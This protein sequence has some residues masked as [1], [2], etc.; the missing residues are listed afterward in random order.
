MNISEIFIILVVIIALFQNYNTYYK[1]RKYDL[2]DSDTYSHLRIAQE[3]RENGWIMKYHT[4]YF[5]GE[6]LL[7][8]YP[9]ML[10]IVLALLQN[11]FSLIFTKC[12][13]ILLNLATGMVVGI[14]MYYILNIPLDKSILSA[15][16]FIITHGILEATRVITPRSFGIL[17]LFLSVVG[18]SEYSTGEIQYCLLVII[19][20][21]CLYLSH[22]MGSQILIIFHVAL[23]IISPLIGYSLMFQFVLFQIISIMI[24]LILTNGQIRLVMTDHWSRVLLHFKY[25]NQWDGNKRLG[26]IKRIIT[27]NS[28]L[29]LLPWPIA[30]SMINMQNIPTPGPMTL[31][32]VMIVVLLL[33]SIFWIWGSGERHIIF[34]S[35]YILIT[36]FEMDDNK[37]MYLLMLAMIFILLIAVRNL[38]NNWHKRNETHNI[39]D[40]SWVK[41]ANLIIDSQEHNILV[42]PDISISYLVYK[43]KKIFISSAHDSKAITFNRLKLKWRLNDHS[44]ILD[45]VKTLN[46]SLLLIG[47]NYNNKYLSEW[48]MKEYTLAGNEAKYNLWSIKRK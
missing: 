16:L 6:K 23:I 48:L 5:P 7:Y 22:R 28:L 30:E 21:T 44:Y 46:P 29:F 24:A 1:I 25:G 41:L 36:Y 26:N 2:V 40:D 19:S 37:S 42:L 47:E 17:F 34:A 3:I 20:S 39:V 13:S 8:T 35:P 43:T 10:H 12:L 27:M 45:S 15:G 18:M 38:S 9:P 31:Y 32:Y 11:R 14:T 33:L 4:C